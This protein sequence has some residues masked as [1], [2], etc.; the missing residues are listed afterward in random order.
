M[1]DHAEGVHS[2]AVDVK[3]G[4]KVEARDS[5]PMRRV[6]RESIRISEMRESEGNEV[7]L[8]NGKDEWFGFNLVNVNFTLD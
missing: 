6:V 2:G 1:W 7:V 8:L 3:Y 4:M 5:D